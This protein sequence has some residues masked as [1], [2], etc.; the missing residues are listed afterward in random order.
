[1]QAVVHNITGDEVGQV[2]LQDSVFGITPNMAVIHQA[3]LRQQANARQGTHSTKT[4]ADVRGGGRKPWR[5]KGTGRARQGST[6][7]PQWRHGGVVFGPHPRS[8]E[9][10]MP[11]KMRRLAIRGVLSAKAASG[12]IVI[13]DDF[14]NLEPR[15][16]AFK[17]ALL[18]WNVGDTTAL[19]MTASR[20]STV[21]MAASNLSKVTIMPAGILSVVDMLKHEYLVI[22]Q[23]SLDLIHTILGTGGGRLKQSLGGNG[24][25]PS[26]IAEPSVVIIESGPHPTENAPLAPD[27]ENSI[28]SVA[29]VER[30]IIAPS[31]FARGAVGMEN[32]A[33][34][35]TGE[36]A[37]IADAS[38]S[39][40]QEIGEVTRQ[41]VTGTDNTETGNTEM[42]DNA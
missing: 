15:T 25:A 6:R 28:G 11:R 16:K 20:N 38:L 9:Q 40:T 26:T 1:M 37:N 18:A 24:H 22:P 12:Q 13:V 5:Q 41:P 35:P 2:E 7:S 19:V 29:G 14:A 32:I 31:S 33:F 36:V 4:R 3:V 42:G 39:D 27:T 30:T 21:E 17:Q 23:A 10:D 8:Y 34:E